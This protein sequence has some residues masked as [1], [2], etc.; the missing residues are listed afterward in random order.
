MAHDRYIIKVERREVL[1]L[2]HNA[3]LHAIL[4][5]ECRH[6]DNITTKIVPEGRCKVAGSKTHAL[7]SLRVKLHNPLKGCCARNIHPT[8]TLNTRQGCRNLILHIV[9]DLLR[10]DSRLNGVG[11]NI[12][13]AAT[14]CSERDIGIAHLLG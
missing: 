14:A 8:D 11:Q 3:S 13:L 7:Q 9:E 5:R 12:L 10:G 2:Q 4:C 1:Q 6:T